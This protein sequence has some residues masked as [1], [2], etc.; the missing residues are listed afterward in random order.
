MILCID[1]GNTNIKVALFDEGVRPIHVWRISSDARR[2]ADEYTSMLYSIICQ[3]YTPVPVIT[4]SAISSVVPALT[5]VFTEV[6]AAI[7][8]EAAFIMSASSPLAIRVPESAVHEIGSDL[9]CDANEVYCRCQS[10]CIVCDAGTALSF[11]AI[12]GGGMI[13]GVAIA[14]GIN[15]A[16]CAL[17]GGTAQLHSV[18]LSLPPSSLGRNTRE[19]I[20]SGVLL[21][22]THLVRGLLTQMQEDLFSITHRPCRT[23]ATG[24]LLLQISNMFDEVDADITLCGLRR[25]MM[26]WQDKR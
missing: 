13:E 9:L 7:T 15:T 22:Y 26:Q 21:G 11:V 20:Q 14:P 25:G 8:G 3:S 10:P 23:F 16:L 6:C 18:P 17:V 2:T 12:G 4:A 19:A 24:G 1:I 5:S